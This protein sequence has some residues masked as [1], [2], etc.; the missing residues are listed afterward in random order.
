MDWE[1]RSWAAWW[2]EAGAAAIEA[3]ERALTRA[4]A[5]LRTSGGGYR[6][7]D[8]YRWVVAQAATG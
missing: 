7:E 3:R 6:I 1:S 2:E 5:P 8:E 4:F